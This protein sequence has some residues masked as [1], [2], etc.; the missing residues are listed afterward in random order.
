MQ[1]LACGRVCCAHK[2]N[3]RDVRK[4]TISDNGFFPKI[5]LEKFSK[6]KKRLKNFAKNGGAVMAARGSVI[7]R[8]IRA[9]E[10]RR[11]VEP[12]V[13]GR[14]QKKKII[15]NEIL[16]RSNENQPG[17]RVKCRV[18]VVYTSMIIVYARCLTRRRMALCKATF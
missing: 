5:N 6:K 1:S 14:G 12:R 15:I 11:T 3:R 9:R 10:T 13:R 2:W 18:Y 4:F 16:L 8:R 7:E 17:S